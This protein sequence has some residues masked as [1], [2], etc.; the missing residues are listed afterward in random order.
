[1]GELKWVFLLDGMRDNILAV[2][3]GSVLKV[4]KKG[5]TFEYTLSSFEEGFS[6]FVEHFREFCKSEEIE[7]SK[8]FDVEVSLE[9]LI[10]NSFSHGSK[11]GPVN[12]TAE[13][14]RGELKVIFQDKGPLFDLM[15]DAPPPPTGS[16]EERKV[17]GGFGIHLIKNLN[18]RVEYSSSKKGNQVTLFKS[19]GR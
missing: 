14:L 16:L 8:I 11:D 18:D 3:Q 7:N 5:P 1:M 10:V 17:A 4:V 12:I 2:V 19:L 15:R 9:E 13:V 6:S